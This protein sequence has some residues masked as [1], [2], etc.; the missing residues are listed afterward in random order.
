MTLILQCKAYHELEG[1]LDVKRENYRLMLH[2]TLAQDSIPPSSITK[3]SSPLPA[4]HVK[5]P[6]Q[7]ILELDG[8]HNGTTIMYFSLELTARTPRH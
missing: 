3:S 8:T 7:G 1:F 5:M 6:S 4:A 2:V